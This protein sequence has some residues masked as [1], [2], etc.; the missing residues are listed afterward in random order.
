[1]NNKL[2][3]MFKIIVLF[4]LSF[5][6]LFSSSVYA[7]TK[8]ANV[9]SKNVSTYNGVY[10]AKENS[11]F[12]MNFQAKSATSFTFVLEMNTKVKMQVIGKGEYTGATS[13]VTYYNAVTG[14]V[15]GK[16]TI[17]FNANSISLGANPFQTIAP[18]M[19]TKNA[20]EFI[21]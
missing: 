16:G 14:K 4:V 13:N 18:T 3:S 7:L 15:T 2:K 11:N 19:N 9:S 17:T 20:F 10:K 1:M 21:K 5:G 12:K 6:M 8:I